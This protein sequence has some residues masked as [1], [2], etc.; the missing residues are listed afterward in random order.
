M[1][2]LATAQ[3]DIMDLSGGNLKEAL[4]RLDKAPKALKRL[5]KAPNVRYGHVYGAP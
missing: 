3:Q 1:S 5:D 4:K 2:T